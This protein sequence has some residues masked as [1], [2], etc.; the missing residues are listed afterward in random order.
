MPQIV[1]IIKPTGLASITSSV[2]LFLWRKTMQAGVEGFLK[3]RQSV[4]W[5]HEMFAALWN[6]NQTAFFKW[7]LGGNQGKVVEWWQTM[8]TRQG[9]RAR[10]GWNRWCVPLGLHGDGVAAA[11]VRG[12]ASKTIDVLS[13]SS[14]LSSGPT[15]FTTYLIYFAFTHTVKKTGLAMTWTAFWKKL[16]LSFRILWSGVWPATTM[17]GAPEPRAGTPLAGGFYGLLYNNKGDLDWMAGHFKL[18]HGSSRQ[19]CSLCK[20]TN[21]GAG[22]DEFPWTDVN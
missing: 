7:I 16:T 20:C 18:A 19:P 4:L 21:L 11:N 12:S 13:W 14:L 2:L 9:L 15:R 8:P 5:P 17:T 22:R 1:R 6:F 3:S 10:P